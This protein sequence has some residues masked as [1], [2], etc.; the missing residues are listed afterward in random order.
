[1]RV[2]ISLPMPCGLYVY[3]CPHELC[4]GLAQYLERWF[5]N[6][7]ERKSDRR[8]GDSTKLERAGGRFMSTE[9]S[10][11]ISGPTCFK[12]DNRRAWL[13]SGGFR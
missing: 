12:Y 4:L 8:Q 3:P 2:A 1:M 11:S 7:P 13:A 5:S 9:Y 10:V 6:R